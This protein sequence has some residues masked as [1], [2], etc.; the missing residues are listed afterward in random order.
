MDVSNL[1]II[2]LTLFS[3]QVRIFTQMTHPCAMSRESVFD[4]SIRSGSHL[5]Q[6]VAHS[7]RGPPLKQPHRIARGPPHFLFG[8]PDR[9]RAVPRHRQTQKKTCNRAENRAFPS[10]RAST[11]ASGARASAAP[12]RITSSS[13]SFRRRVGRRTR[14]AA[15]SERSLCAR[16]AS[17]RVVRS[18]NRRFDR[19]RRCVRPVPR[20]PRRALWP[21]ARAVAPAWDLP[22]DNGAHARRR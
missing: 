5:R 2:S 10:Q 18:A 22:S 7:L 6:F 19:R 3:C 21:E 9:E 17:A 11:R 16:D 12:S 14:P 20:G 8:K 4:G 15:R 1:R 13:S